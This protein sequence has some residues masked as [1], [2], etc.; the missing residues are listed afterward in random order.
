MTDIVER[1]GYHREHP[2]TGQ[3]VLANPD[4]PDAAS[5][6]TALREEVERLTEAR[7]VVHALVRSARDDAEL[8]LKNAKSTYDALTALRQR[9]SYAIWQRFNSLGRPAPSHNRRR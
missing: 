4:G 2:V 1:L 6:I 3:L 7:G 5:T 8:F 9:A